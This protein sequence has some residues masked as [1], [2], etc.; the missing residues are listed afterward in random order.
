MTGTPTLHHFTSF[1]SHLATVPL[2]FLLSQSSSLTLADFLLVAELGRVLLLS[3]EELELFSSSSSSSSSKL[4][5]LEMPGPGRGVGGDKRS[6]RHTQTV[7]R[8]LA[9]NHPYTPHTQTHTRSGMYTRAS[10][11]SHAHI[12]MHTRTFSSAYMSWGWSL[13]PGAAPL[14]ASAV[15]PLLSGSQG[16]LSPG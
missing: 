16:A 15:R 14:P 11:H 1:P 3:W 6:H 4:M 2:A 9:P 5:L 10:T 8:S 13:S 7:T 12:Q